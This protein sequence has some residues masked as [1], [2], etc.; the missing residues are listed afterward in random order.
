MI[1]KFYIS[2]EDPQLWMIE[3]RPKVMDL[4]YENIFD[5]YESG[6]SE[7][8]IARIF[9]SY[10]IRKDGRNLTLD[11]AL[12]KESL[13]DTL[14]KCQLYYEEIEQYERCARLFELKKIM[15]QDLVD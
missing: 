1:K 9:T 8:T 7:K 6:K 4:I 13:S 10:Q 5:F 12:K 14:T 15:E 11:F 3:N 2:D